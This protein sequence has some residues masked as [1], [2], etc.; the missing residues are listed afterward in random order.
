MARRRG[1][2]RGTSLQRGILSATTM[3]LSPLGT[4]IYPLGSGSSHG[5]TFV[6]GIMDTA[7]NGTIS[8]SSLHSNTGL[9]SISFFM[10]GYKISG[11][12]NNGVATFSEVS[13]SGGGVTLALWD[14]SHLA[15]TAANGVSITW[16]AFGL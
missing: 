3:T 4:D 8:G 13:T 5:L 12:T 15:A 1:T 11:T 9:T 14:S 16:M 10:A 6:H 7:N 2:G